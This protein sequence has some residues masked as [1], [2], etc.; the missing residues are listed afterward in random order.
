MEIEPDQTI[1]VRKKNQSISLNFTNC[2]IL[3]NTKIIAQIIEKTIF[4]I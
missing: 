3:E 4:Y 2:I 1:K